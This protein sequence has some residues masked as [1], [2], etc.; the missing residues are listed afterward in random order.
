MA[1]SGRKRALADLEGMRR[2]LPHMSASALSAV[3]KELRSRPPPQLCQRKHIEEAAGERFAEDTPHGKVFY[4]KDLLD[5]A[6]R[7]ACTASFANLWS[8]LHIYLND[9]DSEYAR[10]FW[11]MLKEKPSAPQCRWQLLLYADEVIPGNALGFDQRR[12]LWI[13]Y[14]SWAQLEP[15]ALHLEESWTC[16][17]VIRSSLLCKAA[18]GMSQW[19][20]AFLQETFCGE[21]HVARAGAPLHRVSTG[22]VTWLWPELGMV[23]Q[24]GGAHKVLWQCKGDAGTRFC[25]LCRNVVA[26]TSL[27]STLAGQEGLVSTDAVH[28][29]CLQL[30]SDQDVLGTVDRLNAKRTVLTQEDFGIWQQACGFTYAPLGVLSNPNLRDIVKPVSQYVHDPMHTLLVTG[31]FQ[32][33]MW[34]Y[35]YKTRRRSSRIASKCS[36]NSSA[37]GRCRKSFTACCSRCSLASAWRPAKKQRPSSARLRKG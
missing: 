7:H 28:V 12:K 36:Q 25:M 6:G 8:L 23:L 4:P 16:V 37:G 31:V 20:S 13:L 34:L 1:A 17:G 5:A 9:E 3:C 18:A 29:S 21:G 26:P 22:D 27:A 30:Q 15:H 32:T 33:V 14:V 19:V 24:D 2:R 35:C 10:H 11:R